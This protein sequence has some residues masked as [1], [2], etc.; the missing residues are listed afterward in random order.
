MRFALLALL[1]LPFLS[2]CL[3]ARASPGVAVTV[4]QAEHGAITAVGPGYPDHKRITCD[5]T[6]GGVA[7]APTGGETLLSYSCKSAG[8]VYIGGGSTLSASTGTE[9]TVGQEFGA[10]VPTPERC[11]SAGSVVISCRFLLAQAP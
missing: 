11:I 6:A 7:I 3:E 1:A 10:N 5:T 4:A 9:Y 2:S 8:T